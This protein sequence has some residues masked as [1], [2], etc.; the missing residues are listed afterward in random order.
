MRD[1]RLVS[2]SID[3]ILAHDSIAYGGIKRPVHLL[4]VY[5]NAADMSLGE[6]GSYADKEELERYFTDL[7]GVFMKKFSQFVVDQEIFEE[8]TLTLLAMLQ[9]MI[10]VKK[11]ILS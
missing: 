7:Y 10:K 5:D 9:E 8:D 6:I 2:P 3:T 4:R 1:Y 11:I